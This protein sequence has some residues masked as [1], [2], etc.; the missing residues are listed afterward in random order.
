[1]YYE[2]SPFLSK[3]NGTRWNPFLCPST[4]KFVTIAEEVHEPKWRANKWH[5]KSY[6]CGGA[7]D[8]INDFY[9]QQCLISSFW[10]TAVRTGPVLCFSTATLFIFIACTSRGSTGLISDIEPLWLILIYTIMKWNEI[11]WMKA[12]TFFVIYFLYHV[13]K[14]MMST[15]SNHNMNKTTNFL[16]G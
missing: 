11:F 4:Q 3:Q 1:M 12:M 10:N 14:N 9:S 16:W 6:T 8:D 5:F 7:C 2:G 13:S 15:I